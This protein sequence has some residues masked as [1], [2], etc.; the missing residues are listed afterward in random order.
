MSKKKQPL[1]KKPENISILFSGNF[2]PIFFSISLRA[3][4]FQLVGRR[5]CKE[6]HRRLRLPKEKKFLVETSSFERQSAYLLLL[7]PLIILPGVYHSRRRFSSFFVVYF[8]PY[9]FFRPFHTSSARLS[10]IEEKI[11]SLITTLIDC[12]RDLTEQLLSF[13]LLLLAQWE[14]ESESDQSVSFRLV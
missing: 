12:A 10:N 1:K 3:L 9:P 7:L 11:F 4:N 8:Y 6:R 5:G 2:W 13:L 14:R